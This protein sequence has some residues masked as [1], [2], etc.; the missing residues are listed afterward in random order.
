M[1]KTIAVIGGGPAGMMAAYAAKKACGDEAEVVLYERNPMLGK[2]LRITG[3]GRCNVTNNCTPAEFREAVIRNQKFLYGASSRFTSADTM[4]FFESWGVPLKTERG[5]RVFPVSDKA[6][7]I[8]AAM[9]RALTETGVKIYKGMHISRLAAEDN[10][11][12]DGEEYRSPISFRCGNTV[13]TCDALILATGGVS[14]PGTGSTGDGHRML[15]GMDIPVTDLRPSLVPIETKEKTGELM[16]L[17][18]KNVSLTAY[19]GEKEVFSEQG[20]MLFA[21]FG[22]T[23][24]LVLSASANMQKGS[25]SDYRLTID[26]KPALTMEELDKRLLSDFAKYSARD[27]CNSLDDL[28]PKRLIPWVIRVSGI[29]E[30]CK[31]ASLTKVQRQKLCETL[32]ALPFTPTKF[33]PMDEAIITCG[34]VDVSAVSPKDMMLKK[35]PGV[36]CAGELLD[37]D[38]Y[39]GGYNLQIAFSTGVLAGQGAAAF[40]MNSELR[41]QN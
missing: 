40:V 41:I 21:H 1:K 5:R 17:T 10:S 15:S 33:R 37:L 13:H 26:L 29:P 4:A 24:P 32:K 7:D 20:E 39:T 31:T 18:L 8:A 16:G 6:A 19:R 3:K 30:R 28:L 23:G 34:G 25:V 27:F 38:A 12:G 9:E 36:F 22:L 14:Y 2:K 35:L 11:A